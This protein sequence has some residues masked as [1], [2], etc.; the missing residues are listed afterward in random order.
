[1]TKNKEELSK[2]GQSAIDFRFA[3][4]IQLI[5]SLGIGH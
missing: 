2:N 4:V 1:M 3:Q 5:A